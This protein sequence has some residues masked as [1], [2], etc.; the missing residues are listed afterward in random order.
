MGREI[1]Q[2]LAGR[3]EH[4]L[5]PAALPVH[6]DVPGSHH[7]EHRGQAHAARVRPSTRAHTHV[8]AHLSTVFK[9]PL[10]YHCEMTSSSHLIGGLVSLDWLPRWP[11]SQ[12]CR[13]SLPA[14]TLSSSF[15]R[16]LF[17]FHPQKWFL[18]SSPALEQGIFTLHGTV[19]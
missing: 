16:L 10:K 5:H 7:R 3:P 17:P 4:P 18:S 9:P 19:E 6:A 13:C 11:D 2:R 15:A 8:P 14:F 12:Q 1:R